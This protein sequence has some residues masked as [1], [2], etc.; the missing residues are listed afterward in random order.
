MDI[1]NAKQLK[2]FAGER[3]A[4]CRQQR[5][6]V[7]IYAGILTGMAVLV[8]LLQSLLDMQISKTGGL[9]RKSVV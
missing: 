5:R 7:L 1:R 2:Q 4:Q 6:L 3:V 9:D 8:A